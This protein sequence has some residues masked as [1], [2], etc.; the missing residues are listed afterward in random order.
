MFELTMNWDILEEETTL[1]GN[2]FSVLR[3]LMQ[4]APQA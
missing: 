4:K 1:P 2:A 3:T